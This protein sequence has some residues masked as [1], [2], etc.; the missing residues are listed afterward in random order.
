LAGGGKLTPEQAEELKA[1]ASRDIGILAISM[2]RRSA[3]SPSQP[4]SSRYTRLSRPA[5]RSALRWS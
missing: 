3:R 2:L 5:R 1:L 4:V